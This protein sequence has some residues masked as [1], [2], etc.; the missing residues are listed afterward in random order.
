M[1]PIARF[2]YLLLLFVGMVILARGELVMITMPKPEGM[3]NAELYHESSLPALNGVVVLCPGMNGDGKNLA[4]EGPWRDFAQK[5]GFG[6]VG[7][8]FSS[9][10]ALLYGNPA[11][12]YYYPEQGSGEALL[13]GLRQIYGHDVKLL[14]YGFSGGAQFGSRFAQK[15]PEHMLGWAVYA[16]SFWSEPSF[17]S[18][19][20]APGIVACG[21]FDAE[22]YGPS[23][24][25]F[26]QGRRK[27]ARW[28]WVSLGNVGHM[29]HKRF[30]EFVRAHFAAVLEGKF[31]QAQWLDAETKQPTTEDER[32]LNPALSVWLPTPE[33]TD[34]WL[35]LHHP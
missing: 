30:E 20:D 5:H 25:F 10:P 7:V 18:I 26:Q 28:T 11:N 29:R 34:L 31:D 12:G 21:E 32:L 13:S 16:A 2:K 22:R 1:I 17:A 33:I 14:F 6:L 24:A 9:P 4:A 35:K 27:D 15:Y 19:N 3:T 8:S 23:F